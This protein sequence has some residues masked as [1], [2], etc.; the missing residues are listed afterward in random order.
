VLFPRTWNQYAEV[1]TD[2]AVVVVSGKFDRS[3][4]D[5]Q[6]IVEHVTTQIETVTSGNEPEVPP[7]M[8]AYNINAIEDSEPPFSIGNG[9]GHANGNGHSPY[10]EPPS[11]DE[12][13]PLDDEFDAP[14]IPEKREE[15][16]HPPR[17]L[18]V[19]F[20][21]NGDEARDRRRLERVVGTIKQHTGQDPFEIVIV[22]EGVE[23]H[24]LAF[25]NHKTNY[26]D[27]LLTELGGVPGIE[28]AGDS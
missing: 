19:R 18:T 3:R 20:L 7:Q 28:I 5:P 17:K 1:M 21:R 12:L 13:P 16:A 24:L 25:P 4:N 15:T 23:T 2:G 10:A 26:C 14:F 6:I 8:S 27:R 9:N 11:L 22:T